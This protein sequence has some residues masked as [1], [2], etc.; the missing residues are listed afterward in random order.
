MK[1][2]I[3]LDIRKIFGGFKKCFNEIFDVLMRFFGVKLYLN[4][5]F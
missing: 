2:H 5:S 4:E 1:F 3:F